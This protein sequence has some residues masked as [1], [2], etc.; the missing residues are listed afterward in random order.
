MWHDHPV[1]RSAGA[2]AAKRV[3]RPGE[4]ES[5]RQEILEAAAE[6]FSE[7]GFAAT[8]T[9]AIA[10]AVGIRQASLYYH[11]PSKDSILAELL[12][13]TV[14][15]SIEAASA[16]GRVEGRSVARLHALL[17]FDST[18]L[19]AGRWNLGSLYLLPELRQPLFTAFRQDRIRL[20][21]R[22]GKLIRASRAEGDLTYDDDRLATDLL[23][24]LG[25]GVILIRSDRP[26]GADLDDLV[27]TLPDAGLRMLG[28]SARRLPRVR[29]E[30]TALAGLAGLHGVGAQVLP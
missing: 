26:A 3:G 16:L 20:K 4:G 21:R 12:T 5:S 13:G 10:L 15:P 8:S 2:A 9:R 23:F 7:N 17:R 27:A 24:T 19:C 14:L 28:L 30:A 18:L 1:S 25:E 29:R 22:Y 6:L 11:F